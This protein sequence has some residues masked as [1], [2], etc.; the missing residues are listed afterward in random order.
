MNQNTKDQ[1]WK[2]LQSRINKLVVH[3]LK[4]DFPAIEYKSSVAGLLQ[5][6][7]Q[8]IEQNVEEIP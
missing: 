4:E 2:A 7:S 1:E 3:F 6:P 8:Y 5:L